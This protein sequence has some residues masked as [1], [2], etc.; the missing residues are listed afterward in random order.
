MRPG[1]C[2]WL[3]RQPRAAP[4][5]SLRCRAAMA[6]D[7]LLLEL[8][9]RYQEPHRHYHTLEHIGAMLHAGRSA[10][11]DRVQTMAVWFH[12]AVYDPR[13]D[14]NEDAS[15]ELAGER[16]RAAGWPE[17]DVARVQRI[18]LDTKAHA[19]T[20]PGAAIVLDLDLMSLALPWPEFRRNTERIR[21]EFAHV[22]DADFAAGRARFFAAM[23]GRERLFHSELG[24]AW[25]APARANLQRASRG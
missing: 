4:R 17:A 2:P 20:A 10:P 24:A 13:S 11:L 8:T 3:C 19:P 1:V 6:T 23:L 22:A 5:A 21:A 15:A 25:E 7:D 14:R 9:R 16:L 18:V 12:D